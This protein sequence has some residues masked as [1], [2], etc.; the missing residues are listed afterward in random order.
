[1]VGERLVPNGK[2]VKALI[3]GFFPLAHGHENRRVVNHYYYHD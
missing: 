2:T 1:V 3:Q